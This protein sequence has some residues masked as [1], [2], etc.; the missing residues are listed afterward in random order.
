MLRVSVAEE[1]NTLVRLRTL[2]LLRWMA[3]GGQA[4]AIVVAQRWFGLDIPL[5]PCLA[6][7][8]A[9][10]ITNL[11][12]SVVYPGGKRLSWREALA[13]QVFDLVQLAALL[14]LTGGLSNPFILLILAPVTISATLL[15]ARSTVLIGAL[16]VGSV[17][18]LA[19][20]NVPLRDAA[21]QALTLP[22]VF[23]FGFW[24]AIVI[25]VIFLGFYAHRVSSEIRSMSQALLATQMA[26]AREQK[27]TDLG[28]VIA[29]AAH[30]LGTPLATIKLASAELVSDLADRPDLTDLRD[31]ARLIL[32]QADRCR[33]I[34]RSMGRAGK[35]DRHMRQA[36]LEAVLREAAEP[37][38]S[39]GR[40]IAFDIGPAEGGAPAQPSVL[41]R[42]EV[43]HGLRNLIQNAVDFAERRVWIDGHWTDRRLIVRIADDG[44]GYPAQVLKTIG[45]PF[46]RQRA[47]DAGLAGR[48]SYEGMGLGLF[49]A[50]TLLER[51]GAELTFANG[52]DPF[53]GAD[54]RPD[55]AGAIVEV[56]WPRGRIEG[57][58]AAALGLNTEIAP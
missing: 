29:A 35:E 42:P 41:R 49:I 40:V 50:K 31:D 36:P 58:P 28:G 15:N 27:M 22:P 47:S 14:A 7:I 19:F 2:T 44:P 53:L 38:A 37:H 33:D 20:F 52:T 23:G 25:G 24:L 4:A 11:V 13:I 46:M 16:A 3:A 48:A 56:V 54:E 18:T 17:T 8:G 12:A 55:R 39:R 5:G 51:S 34:L 6:L 1:A 45:E 30:E 9:S 26:L 21:G 32:Q 43:V 57:D 10:V